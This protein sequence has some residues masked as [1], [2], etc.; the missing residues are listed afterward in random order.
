MKKPFNCKI[1]GLIYYDYA[2]VVLAIIE[3]NECICVGCLCP[4]GDST[5]FGYDM[6][7]D[8]EKPRNSPLLIGIC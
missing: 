8:V 1:V 5:S 4:R 7:R 6:S 3:T 2:I